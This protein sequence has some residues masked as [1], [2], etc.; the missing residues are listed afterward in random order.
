MYIKY[1]SNNLQKYNRSTNQH[2][3][4]NVQRTIQTID[5]HLLDN[6][7]EFLFDYYLF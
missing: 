1:T 3:T 6:I 5:L 7:L 2:L 4:P